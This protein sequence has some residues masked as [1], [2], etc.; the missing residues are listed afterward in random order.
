MGIFLSL[1]MDKI[2]TQKQT[3]ILITAS[4]WKSYFLK[5]S[6]KIFFITMLVF[7]SCAL[8]IYF[9]LVENKG[10][11]FSHFFYIPIILS[12]F[13]WKK[14]GLPVAFF[15]ASFL[16]FG[17]F[18]LRDY[19][20]TINDYFRAVMFIIVPLSVS[21]LGEKIT[22]AEK[23]I[24]YL[25]LIVGLVH[26][27]NRLVM[28]EFDRKRLS[29]GIAAVIADS[30]ECIS[31][32]IT[33]FNE[34]GE[35]DEKIIRYSGNIPASDSVL[36]CR[37]GNAINKTKPSVTLCRACEGCD[38]KNSTCLA[39]TLEYEGL[40]YGEIS[41]LLSGNAM[42]DNEQVN[43]LRSISD[44]LAYALYNLDIEKKRK[45]A[46]KELRLD[47]LRIKTISDFS[48]ITGSSLEEMS[49]FALGEAVRISKSET[50]YIAFINEKNHYVELTT[51][52]PEKTSNENCINKKLYYDLSDTETISDVIATCR[53]LII[54]EEQQ[55]K[56][57]G[58]MYATGN[59][60]LK[61]HIDIPVVISEKVAVVVGLGNRQSPYEESVIKNIK[62]LMQGMWIILQHRRSEEELALYRENLVDMVKIKTEELEYANDRLTIELREKNT[63]Y[64]NLEESSRELESFVYS[65][66]HDL[67]SPLFSMKLCMDML[68]KSYV[69]QMDQKGQEILYQIKKETVR[70]EELIKDVL[71]LSRI[72]VEYENVEEINILKLLL[73]ISDRFGYFF[74][75]NSVEFVVKISL[76]EPLPTMMA[77]P[78]Q[79][80]Q[81]FENLLT[82]AVKFMDDEQEPCVVVCLD[83]V[84]NG[85]C[86]FYVED[87][88]IGIAEKNHEKIFKEFY[89]THD[90]EVE[91]TGIGLAIVKKI[92]EKHGGEISIS[93]EPG[94]GST[95][96]FSLP[97]KQMVHR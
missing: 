53:P 85:F 95:F 75:E 29:E 96:Y 52:F 37:Q 86:R 42:H 73:D 50:G 66:T 87:N 94:K 27:V 13:W 35:P 62:L 34:K 72:G 23:K 89:R 32:L 1:S 21:F 69:K 5:E 70:M 57:I 88:G 48:K 76:P 25:N 90:I 9:H 8:T 79:V 44:E 18:F 26:N 14:R 60:I 78:S 28:E 22:R 61:R 43:L 4:G 40:I 74:E 46:E 83:S 55:L 12:A 93:S 64:K 97:V 10:T 30:P 68:I 51:L 36:T 15:L 2:N 45:K 20:I 92:I 71:T 6:S 17:H 19:V 82:N 77:N 59:L 58:N 56:K 81:V 41:V 33:L 49:M 24:N 84:E 80:I 11:V 3:S 39:Y 91:G 31:V 16:L 47:E 65:V 63:L 38:N 54:E 67:K 7:F